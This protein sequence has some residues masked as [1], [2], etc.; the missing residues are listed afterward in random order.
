ME[1]PEA[2]LVTGLVLPAEL[3][4]DPQHF[5]EVNGGFGRGLDPKWT[6]VES[7]SRRRWQLYGT[8][9]YGTGANMAYRRLVFDQ[10]GWFDPA[11]DVGTVTKGGGDL[12]MFFRALKFG[13]ILVYEPKAIVRHYH[14][15]EFADLQSQIR[16]NG[17]GLYAYFVRSALNYPEERLAFLHLGA[18]W[19]WWW[20]IRRLILSYLAPPPV[21]R[22]LIWSELKGSL[23]GLTRYRK[24]ERIAAEV[25]SH[26]GPQSGP[27]NPDRHQP[28]RSPK[29][30]S[31]AVG[32]R[33]V[34]LSE[35]L[36]GLEDLHSYPRVCVYV[37]NQNELL[38]SFVIHN[39]Y[40]PVSLSRLRAGIVT[41]FGVKLLTPAQKMD[42][43]FLK[44]KAIL[45][46][47]Q[48]YATPKLL[49]GWG[50]TSTS[51]RPDRVV[52]V[53]VAT[54]DHPDDLRSC[55]HHLGRQRISR[56]VEIVVVDNNPASGLTPPVVAEFPGVLLVN[57]SRRGLAYAR[58]AGFAACT[59]EIVVATDDDVTVPP[60][61]LE[62][63][64]EPFAR[65]DVMVVTG[66]VLPMELETTAQQLF[67]VYGGLG[68]GI[69]PLEANARWF[70]SFEKIAVPTWELGATANSAFRTQ[71]FNHPQIGLMDEALGPG[72]PSGVGED[73]YLFYKVLQ[74][75]YT[76]VYRPSA[77]V[78]HRHRRSMKALRRQLFN[79][80]K[81]HVAYHLTTLLHDGDKR[82]IRHLLFQ[83]P[84]YRLWQFL[85]YT[86]QFLS[87]SWFRGGEHFPLHL[88][89]I[90]IWGNLVGPWALWRSRRRV[91]R[92]GFSQAY[93]PP[94]ERQPT[95]ATPPYSPRVEQPVYSSS[96][97]TTG[98]NV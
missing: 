5:F 15:R 49:D 51:L 62:K 21:P 8:G 27:K 46:L 95:T 42:D 98:L 29:P 87:G 43:C 81:G 36:T 4:T 89:L 65:P 93:I 28:L 14:R 11:L 69:K 1:N 70:Q 67:E 39:Q 76:L 79:Y 48:H 12:E 30:K 33:L 86:L 9:Q 31:K 7:H 34:D 59:G 56:A 92:E 61:W 60:D 71:I 52:S 78:W 40:Q 82:V 85:K 3:E 19:L 63:M 84:I 54:L 13:H 47:S 94:S 90:E 2:G 97:P 45:A 75:G 83:M 58:N 73:T 38:G 68:R 50:M 77:Y 57:E 80:S 53:V 41:K 96:R 26:F 64:V 88:T 37:V 22:D 20:S 17:I 24:A 25:R 10:I 35:S 74:A 16:N 32:V 23:K 55:L 91:K 44:Q 72:M 66:N 18:W 6:R